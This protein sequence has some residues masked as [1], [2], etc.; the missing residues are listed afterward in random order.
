VLRIKYFILLTVISFVFFSC[1]DEEDFRDEIT[2]IYEFTTIHSTIRICYDP[3][4]DCI[5]G[6]LI[7]VDTI[8]CT[9]EVKIFGSNQ[10]EIKF[11][12]GIIGNFEDGELITYTLYPRYE[13]KKLVFDDYP[14]GSRTGFT[15]EIINDR[16]L[17]NI[18]YGFFLGG[19]ERYLVIGERLN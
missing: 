2:G 19:Y 1:E 4:E 16:I 9:S 11:G 12:E 6:S 17:I 15:G 8:Y 5:D 7:I 13:N 14:I 18:S 10:L 3:S